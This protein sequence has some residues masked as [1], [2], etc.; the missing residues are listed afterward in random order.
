[1][2]IEGEVLVQAVLEATGKVQVLKVVRGLGH[3][4]DEEAIRKAA[5]I[6]FK[7]ATRDGLPSDSTVVLHIIFQLA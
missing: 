5:E 3:G 6:R 7:P 1:M 2:R 4:L